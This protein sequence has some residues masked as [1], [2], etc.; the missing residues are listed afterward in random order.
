M[1]TIW[2]QVAT[3]SAAQI[4]EEMVRRAVTLFA[5]PAHGFQV[6]AAPGWGNSAV[7]LPGSDIDGI[8]NAVKNMGGCD[9]VY[10]IVN[11]VNPTLT[12][13][14]KVTDPVSRRWLLIDVDRNKDNSPDDPA[15]EDELESARKLTEEVH[16]YLAEQ[17]WPEPVI[18]MS[19]NGWQLNYRIELNN[20]DFAR[21][22][23][24][25]VLHKLNEQFQGTYGDVDRNVSKANQLAK[26][27]GCLVKKGTQHTDRPYRVAKLVFAPDSTQVV[28]TAKLEELAGLSGP[29]PKQNGKH[30]VFD[31]A[32][33]DSLKNYVN[34]AFDKELSRVYLASTGN[35][36]ETLNKAAYSLAGF[37]HLNYF[38]REHLEERLTEAALQCG[39]KSNEIRNTLRSG[40]DSGVDEPRQVPGAD[41]GK[42]TEPPE[43]K[44]KQFA[45]KII[46]YPASAVR[47]RKILWV[48]D[49]RIPLGKMT[50]F[51]G[52]G[53]LGKTFVLCDMASR[54]SRGKDWP[55]GSKSHT[56]SIL[57]ISGED[58]PEDTL[59][60]RL[61]ESEADLRKVFFLKFEALDRFT[62]AD[63]P[64]LDLAAEQ[65]GNDLQLVI[66][67]PP[68]SYMGGVDDHKNSELRSLLS[69]L[70]EWC[71][72]RK[73][74]LIF[75]TH[76]NKSQGNVE[77]LM[78]V[79]GS[80]AWVNAVRAAHIFTEDP[81]DKDK[82]LFISMKLNVGR[83]RKGLSYK[84]LPLDSERARVEWL[85]DVDLS[86][87]D[88]MNRTQSK[89][90]ADSA[91][92][93]LIERFKEK[94]E[95]P[96]DDLF[97]AAHHDG[98]SRSAV[99]EA[100]RV[101]DLP[102]AR[103]TVLQDGAAIWVW[104]VPEDWEHFPAQPSNT[105]ERQ[106]KDEETF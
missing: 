48:W 87:N 57:F 25:K 81:D 78:R 65:I 5:D 39:L 8:V 93:W 32:A 80:V 24:K 17:G 69:P 102:R 50:V 37:L 51:A 73:L 7:T 71:A 6:Q 62:L 103:K 67:D 56:G 84:I 41:N 99:F 95:W 49:G 38:S 61:I 35:R 31:P 22:L 21:V 47:P 63:V 34:A 42:T 54:I 10:W 100:K 59:V 1:P 77:A 53:G 27:P 104:W 76:V 60:P 94:L 26:M 85:G 3:G 98:M 64:I 89:T 11:P 36:N 44:L 96:S 16:D 105:T 45:G 23:V 83:E 12:S 86:A 9:R 33:S 13:G 74:A 92:E 2:E 97:K 101:L 90:R 72:R 46:V 15:T 66:I 40:I 30:T 14:A 70:K 75:N 29:Q 55:D 28:P 58:D 79:M 4:D 19:G 52:R 68:T 20:D 106:V 88:A 91:R 82:R 43:L 18:V